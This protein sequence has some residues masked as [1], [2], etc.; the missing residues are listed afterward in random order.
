MLVCPVDG[1]CLREDVVSDN[2]SEVIS[3]TSF[4][5]DWVTV[6]TILLIPFQ[7]NLAIDCV[8]AAR[9]VV[10][11]DGTPGVILVYCSPSVVRNV[12]TR[13]CPDVLSQ[14]G[15]FGFDKT[16]TGVERKREE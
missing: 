2:S 9:N 8:S 5:R 6:M 10:T 16:L 4:V 7:E 1:V 11:K 3:G 15:G 12:P 14:L 13:G